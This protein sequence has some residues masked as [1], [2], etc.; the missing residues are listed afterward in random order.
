LKKAPTASSSPATTVK[1]VQSNSTGP[2]E[3]QP[4]AIKSQSKVK[5]QN[6]KQDSDT[7]PGA[8]KKSQRFC[9]NCNMEYD[10][11][12]NSDTSCRYHPGQKSLSYGSETSFIWECCKKP[13][14]ESGSS[15]TI[16]AVL[17]GVAGVGKSSVITRLALQ[18]FLE[19][20]RPPEVFDTSMNSYSSQIYHQINYLHALIEIPSVPSEEFSKP[21][22][23]QVIQQAEIV[24]L[25]CAVD[26][27]QSL[28]KLDEYY[29]K[30]QAIR[31]DKVCPIILVANKA[32]VLEEKRKITPNDLTTF[33]FGSMVIEFS[34]KTGM[35]MDDLLDIMLSKTLNN[36]CSVSKHKKKSK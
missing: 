31:K 12:T 10:P 19:E 35:G 13:D 14:L 25:I 20:I 32:D 29:K 27:L 9:V 3:T 1:V 23:T 34:A 24:L 15:H 4:Q 8:S 6:P 7:T 11:V 28:L 16:T 18:Q 33:E 2:L 21:E 36:G 22:F 30:I 17:V 5:L 26:D